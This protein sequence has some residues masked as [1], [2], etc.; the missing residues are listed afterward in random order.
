MYFQS[1]PTNEFAVADWLVQSRKGAYSS[2]EIRSRLVANAIENGC[3]RMGC[4]WGSWQPN[5]RWTLYN[6]ATIQIFAS[7]QTT[8]KAWWKTA[9]C[10][11]TANRKYD[12]RTSPDF[13]ANHHPICQLSKHEPKDDIARNASRKRKLSGKKKLKQRFTLTKTSNHRTAQKTL[14][15]VHTRTE[16]DKYTCK[17]PDSRNQLDTSHHNLS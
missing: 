16:Y 15:T 17:A 5:V 13:L 12:Q 14:N 11:L 9:S 3:M 1:R 6:H 4:L 2:R 8:S 7:V 10:A